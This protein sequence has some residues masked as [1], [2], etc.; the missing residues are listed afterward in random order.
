[1]DVWVALVQENMWGR[2]RE[3]G[4]GGLTSSSV[5]RKDDLLV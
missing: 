5:E 4:G 1:V 2:E 3:I